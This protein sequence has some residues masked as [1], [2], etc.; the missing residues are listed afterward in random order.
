MDQQAERIVKYCDG[1]LVK[2]E[3]GKYFERIE[4]CYGPDWEEIPKSLFD[5]ITKRD[6]AGSVLKKD[7]QCES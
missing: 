3:G 7:C 4:T 6:D 1:L 2:E 5:Q